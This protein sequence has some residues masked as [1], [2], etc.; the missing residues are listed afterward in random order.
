M[1]SSTKCS[2]RSTAISRSTIL[3]RSG[4]PR[5]GSSSSSRPGGNGRAG[6]AGAGS[7]DPAVA[8]QAAVPA[9][10]VVARP[11]EDRVLGPQLRG[12]GPREQVPAGPA[13]DQLP[14]QARDVAPGPGGPRRVGRVG[15]ARII[16]RARRSGPIPAM[17]AGRGRRRSITLTLPSGSTPS[18]GSPSFATSSVLPSCVNVTMSGSGPVGTLARCCAAGAEELDGARIGAD[19]RPATATATSVLGLTST[20]FGPP[21][22]GAR[23]IE[24]TRAGARRARAASKTSSRFAPALVAKIR[25]A[26]GAW[27]AISAPPSPY[28]GVP[29]EQFEVD[30]R[31]V[32]GGRRP[33]GGRAR[34]ARRA[35]WIGFLVM[36]RRYELAAVA[37][38]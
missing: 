38:M 20:E 32:R 24:R 16:A 37:P 23:S 8:A 31:G 33:G 15:H 26:P 25:F 9:A 35:R 34:P 27:A 6:A 30:G 3:S 28:A 21:P 29:A 11:G 4:R 13:R 5:S 22:Y 10:A 14:V 17:P 12:V 7:G 18:A 1:V 2:A 19:R 36:R